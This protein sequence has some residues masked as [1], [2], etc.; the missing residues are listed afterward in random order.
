MID[1][2]NGPKAIAEAHN[3]IWFSAGVHPHEAGREPD[4]TNI[5]AILTAAN[6]PECVAIGEAGLDYFYDYAT[7]QQQEN[8]FRAQITVAR[9]LDL[10]IIVHAR[11]AD[12]DMAA[13]LE[14]EMKRD[15]FVA[16]CIV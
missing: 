11:D 13:I 15:L 14:D 8:S 3:N 10:P 1:N 7:P 4:A 9:K 5:D 16:L 2:V 12:D 6:H